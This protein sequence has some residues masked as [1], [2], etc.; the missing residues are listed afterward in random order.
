MLETRAVA[1]VQFRTFRYPRFTWMRQRVTP[2]YHDMTAT[3][4][5]L[6]FHQP[7]FCGGRV[8]YFDRAKAKQTCDEDMTACR[9]TGG[10]ASSRQMQPRNCARQAN[11]R[12]PD[13][14]AVGPLPSVSRSAPPI[15]REG[16]VEMSPMSRHRVAT[17]PTAFCHPAPSGR[18]LN[19]RLPITRKWPLQTEH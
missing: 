3:L 11:G 15:Q 6:T 14:G 12:R 17:L 5:V 13:G 19:R 1:L 8:Q 16:A 9:A 2:A 10:P 7:T 18:S 4:Y